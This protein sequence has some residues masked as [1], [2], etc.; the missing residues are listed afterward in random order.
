MFELS[1][2][3]VEQLIE[4][5]AGLHFG[6]AF[7]S[8]SD[9]DKE[10]VITNTELWVRRINGGE[11]SWPHQLGQ[12]PV[13]WQMVR[14]GWVVAN[15]IPARPRGARVNPA[16]G[17]RPL[18]INLDEFLE[19][20]DQVVREALVNP[21]RRPAPVPVAGT[22]VNE[23]WN[24]RMPEQVPRKYR[25]GLVLSLP[26]EQFPYDHCVGIEIEVEDTHIKPNTEAYKTV[27]EAFTM[28]AE[29]SL[30]NGVEFVT[31]YGVT[32][33]DV[34]AYMPAVNLVLEQSNFSFRCGLHVH[35]DVT[36]HTLEEL[37]RVFL[38]YSV[39]ENIL[40]YISGGR[41]LLNS[42]KFCVEVQT[43]Q[44]AVT[45]AIHYGQNRDW[46]GFT[47]AVGDATKY[48][49]MNVKTVKRYGTIEFRHHEGTC[50]VSKIEK[51]MKVL[52]DLVLNVK[53]MT[54]QDLESRILDLNTDSQY[55]MFLRDCFPNS[56]EFL[57][58]VPNFERMMYPGVSYV[59]EA[60]VGE[61][62]TL[63]YVERD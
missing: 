45:N 36:G 19:V 43:S 2:E 20:P 59:K 28:K 41:N 47:N 31:R 37:Y 34:L 56:F 60:F 6:E 14:D 16:A 61:P 38:V 7:N 35:I 52:L 24:V 15:E 63:A 3:Q 8:L 62:E 53:D 26:P 57:R 51:W 11:T 9:G 33:G 22:T 42:V 5:T 58:G 12:A 13:Q 27:Q 46:M 1:E 21:R 29:G 39:V 49:A 32:A 54:T 55:L 40:F 25:E 4:I 50:E 44:N 23:Y 30:R 18:R 17:L 48:M 10:F